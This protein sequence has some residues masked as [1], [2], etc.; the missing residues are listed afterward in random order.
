MPTP[1]VER[2]HP[3]DAVIRR[4]NPVAR[5][6]LRSR[7][8]GPVSKQLLVLRYRGRR[9]GRTYEL[10]VGYHDIDGDCCLLTNSGW[11]VNFRGGA[12]V[13]LV[14]RGEHRRAHAT[15][16]EDPDTVAAVYQDMIAAL[17]VKQAQ[18]R[19]GIRVNVDR[20]PTREELVDAIQRSGLSIVRLDLDPA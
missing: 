15:L 20:A 2:V 13:E 3:P 9:S 14:L 10:P 5:W 11:R 16:V 1:A 4:V 8:H 7:F 6:L 12:P 18:R 19:L 17:G